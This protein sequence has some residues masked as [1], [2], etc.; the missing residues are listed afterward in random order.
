MA[1]QKRIKQALCA[2]LVGGSFF[3]ISS[4]ADSLGTINALK[5]KKILFVVTSHD[6]MGETKEKTG[7]WLDELAAPYELL[8]K[9]GAEISFASPMGGKPPID[10]V[11]LKSAYSTTYTTIFS[12][13]QQ[14]Q[15]SLSHS[16]PLT[17]VSSQDYDAVF[18]PGGHGPLFD[19]AENRD[20]IRLIEEFAKAKKPLAFVCH[21][22]AVL[23]EVKDAKGDYLVK[24]RKVTA[25]SNS[26]EAGAV[27]SR[28]YSFVPSFVLKWGESQ[29]YKL[30]KLPTDQFMAKLHLQKT[31]PFLT[32]TMLKEEGA[33]YQ[34]K[35]NW[36]SFTV[37]DTTSSGALLLT[38]QNPQS[39]EQIGKDLVAVL[40]PAT[41]VAEG[42]QPVP[43]PK[44]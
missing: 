22:P 5:G 27:L 31:I 21:A 7:Y 37:R 16:V 41:P 9:A 38:G 8:S 28:K 18:Y 1:L 42:A 40:T 26:E 2:F 4:F 29:T 15:E 43:E 44:K 34:R 11:S 36:S 3:P 39:S 20:S 10:P 30:A 12:H 6:Q 35:P 24:G 13:D 17:S 25:F 23:K 32:E 33:N 19:L 14:A